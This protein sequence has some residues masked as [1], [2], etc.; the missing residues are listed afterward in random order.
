V[1]YS[2]TVPQLINTKVKPVRSVSMQ[3]GVGTKGMG[4]QLQGKGPADSKVNGPWLNGSDSHTA[5]NPY[6]TFGKFSD[7]SYAPSSEI[8]VFADD[9]PWTINDAALAVIASQPD[10]VD[11]I[12]PFHDNA[13]GFA[14]ADGHAE[15]HKW[16]TSIWLHNAPPARSDFQNG[17]RATGP[18]SAPGLGYND[19]YWFAWHATRRVKGIAIFPGL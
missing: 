5:D 12:S 6:A 3:Q 7:F 17:A 19:W 14:F 8:W 4:F 1:P 18:V 15:I 11:Y 2:G 16:K 13:T 9:D 10:T